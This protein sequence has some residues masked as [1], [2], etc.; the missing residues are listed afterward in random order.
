MITRRMVSF[1]QT[2]YTLADMT[3]IPDLS[4]E[5]YNKYEDDAY[6]YLAVGWLGEEVRSKGDTAPVILD[7]LLSAKKNNKISDDWF[8]YHTCEICNAYEDLD[9]F[10]VPDGTTKYVLPNMVI[11]YI[12]SHGYRLPEVVEMALLNGE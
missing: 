9:E 7:A 8:G 5:T 3:Y 2:Q 11:H 12:Q 4:P 10:F 6:T 1:I